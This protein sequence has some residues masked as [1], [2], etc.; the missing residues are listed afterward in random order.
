MLML[1]PLLALTMLTMELILVDMAPSDGTLTTLYFLPATNLGSFILEWHSSPLSCYT[2]GLTICFTKP[3][4]QKTYHSST[5][6]KKT[7]WPKNNDF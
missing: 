6:D 2:A 1:P 7:K 5:L 3:N 4:K